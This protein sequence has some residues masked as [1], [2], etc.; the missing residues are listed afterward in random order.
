MNIYVC[1]LYNNNQNYLE[2]SG[3]GQ[4]KV[5]QKQK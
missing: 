3:T 1:S 2:E 5:I 4:S